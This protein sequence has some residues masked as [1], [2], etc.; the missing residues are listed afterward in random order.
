ME[1]KTGYA[2]A[3]NIFD[4]LF[5]FFSG[6]WTAGVFLDGWAHTHLES[7]LETIFTPWHAVFYSGILAT[8][9]L[10]LFELWK[11]HGKGYNWNRSLPREYIFAFYGLILVF[12]GGPGD[13]I[14]HE[15]FGIEVGIEALLS[16]THILLAFGGAM[17]VSA[18]LHAIWYR[19]SKI[20]KIPAIL[21]FSCL[22]MT[23]GFMLQFLH[24]FNFPWMAQSFLNS[25]H[26]NINWGGGLGIANI[27]VFTGIF[28]GITLASIRH[29]KFPFG[30]FAT[31]LTLN[32]FA[33]TMMHGE[34]YIFI[35]T[36][37][38]AGILIDI[39]YQKVYA[40]SLKERHIRIFGIFT[41]IILFTT[42][43]ITILLI[44]TTPWSIHMW[45]GSIVISG[46]TGGL[47][48]YLVVPP[49]DG[50]TRD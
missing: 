17:V 16:P 26:I 4:W 7:T 25:N 48:T 23:L 44:D 8:G 15:L 36:A 10:V 31:I 43:V 11:N 24:P 20:H 6:W 14:W 9:A 47:M 34:Y 12:I 18:P 41:P 49:G 39:L 38:I 40:L 37:L 45:L 30:S 13:L 21:S 50:I 2:P 3:N 35:L 32:A 1:Q 42:Y 22:L 19:S 29:W 28:M 33:I 46:I 27:I 5:V